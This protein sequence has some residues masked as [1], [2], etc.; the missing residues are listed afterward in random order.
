M[1][2][3]HMEV[4]RLSAAAYMDLFYIYVFSHSFPPIFSYDVPTTR[5]IGGKNLNREESNLMTELLTPVPTL[6]LCVQGVCDKADD[7]WLLLL[8]L[9][10]RPRD[11]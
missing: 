10:G 11:P 3:Y 9:S 1:Y 8:H 4:K 2:S 5:A 7:V 6:P